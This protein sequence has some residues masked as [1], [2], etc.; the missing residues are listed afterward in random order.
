MKSS[1]LKSAI[2]T[3]IQ[4]LPL[5]SLQR[6]YSY[7]NE[8]GDGYPG[9]LSRTCPNCKQCDVDSTE[10]NGWICEGCGRGGDSI[11]FIE[12]KYLI[13]RSEAIKHIICAAFNI[14]TKNPEQVAEDL[15]WRKRLMSLAV[16]ATCSKILET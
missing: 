6:L 1:E 10:K 3:L 4:N 9:R 2:E 7:E 16:D 15:L 12:Q 13:D 11:F 14:S 5:N 8:G